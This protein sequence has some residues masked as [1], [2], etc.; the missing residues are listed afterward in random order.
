[1]L[2]KDFATIAVN[3]HESLLHITWLRQ[4]TD[5]EFK[6]VYKT[7]LETALQNELRYFLSDN[8]VGINLAMALQSWVAAYGAE[9]IEHLKLERYAR[10]VPQDVFHEI[11][12]YKMYEYIETMDHSQLEFKVFYKLDDAR[13]WLLQP[14][15]PQN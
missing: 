13:R 3:H 14:L 5:E 2:K 4:T 7:G 11:V 6:E 1:M 9:I 12:S 10:V 8:S 15:S